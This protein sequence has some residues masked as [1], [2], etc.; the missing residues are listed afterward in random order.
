MPLRPNPFLHV[1]ADAIYNPL[2]DATL[3]AG[4][5]EYAAV[6]ALLEGRAAADATL[7]RGGWAAAEGE[8]LSR[9]YRLKVV[10]LETATACNQRCSFCP[11]SIDPR[12]PHAMPDELFE[13]IVNELTTFRSTIE[14]VFL[15]S[16]NEPTVEVRF[17]EH[18]LRL[19][20]AGL[21]VAVL[22]N[23]TAFTPAK[24]DALVAAGGLRFLCIN[25]STLDRERYA[26]ERG[27]DHL[28]VVLRHLDHLR[29][30]P[31]AS[32]MK[33]V[34]LGDGDEQH[35]RDADAIRERFRGSRFAIEARL[36]MD[37]AGRLP[38]GAKPPSPIRRLA[39]CENIGSRPL[40]HLHITPRGL[41]VLCCEDYDEKYVAGDLTRSAIAEVLGGDAFARLR[42]WAYGIEAAPEDFLCRRCVY[43]RSR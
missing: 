5:A 7:L 3:R 34:V 43:A 14:G 40:Q 23:A 36:A 11:V 28:P 29:D 30:R 8:E 15:Q 38:I 26:R 39:G 32:E 21:P 24:A 2:T 4:D 27:A 17:V 6:L 33:I 9:A 25:L 18:C 37:R 42:R 12:E 16:Y 19:M 31:V 10:S 13:R 1:G 35:A 41:C 20:A 22:S